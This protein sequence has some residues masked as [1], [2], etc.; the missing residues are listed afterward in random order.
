M[1]FGIFYEHQLPRPWTERERV[2]PAPGLARPRS[3]WPTGSATTT[4]GRSS[5][6]SWR[7]TRTPR[8][9]RCS[10]ARRA[11]APAASGSA[12]GSSSSPPTTRSASPSAWPRST[13]SR[14]GRV[15]LGLGEGQ[16]PVELHPFGARVREKR[17]VWE[18]A[19]RALVPCFTQDV[20]GVARQALR[21]PRPQ[22]HPQAVPEAAPAAL[23]R[24]L[25]HRDHRQRRP[26]G[27]GRARLPVRLA[28][29]RARLGEQVLHQPDPAPRPSS[30]TIR[31]TRTSRW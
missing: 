4:R 13:S 25:E 20:L 26:L 12:T 30:P 22:R 31:R 14:G 8:R 18:E 10:S 15:E 3:S 16:G 23:G 21:L 19:V 7:S 29:G 11:S 28:G 5:I 24:V 6:T 2:R 17:D 1:K 9:P 27:D